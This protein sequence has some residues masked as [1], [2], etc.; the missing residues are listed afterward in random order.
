VTQAHP[1][2]WNAWFL[3]GWGRRRLGQYA[4][5]REAFERSL[6]IN[7]RNPD[8]LNELAICLAELGEPAESRR[9]LEEARSLDPGNPKIL[10]NLGVAALRMGDEP[11]A[12]RLFQAVLEMDPADPIAKRFLG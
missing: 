3:L 9:R 8:A 12:R 7:P 11:E 10:S 6:K 2:L 1:E 4:E 5:A